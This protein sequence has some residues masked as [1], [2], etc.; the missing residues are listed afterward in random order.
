MKVTPL[1]FAMCI[2]WGWHFPLLPRAFADVYDDNVV[3]VLDASGSMDERMSGTNIRKIDAAKQALKG[4]V[5]KIPSNTNVGF[6]VFSGRGYRD[7]WLYP[8]SQK[9]DEKLLFA[10]DIPESGG[11]TPLGEYIKKGADILLAQREKQHGYGTF[12]LLVVTDGEAN[13]QGRVERYTPEVIARGIRVDVIGVNMAKDH[14]LATRVHS[15]R[16]AND[17]ES[18]TKALTEVFAEVSNSS[19]DAASS[20]EAFEIVGALP[21]EVATAILSSLSSTGNHPIG[22][23]PRPK[24][25]TQSQTQGAPAVQEGSSGIGVPLLLLIFVMVAG[26]IVFAIV[27]VRT[28]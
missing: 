28:R 12:R 23:K 9:N 3:I 4:V 11:G 18:F 19:N 14:T 26:V 17:P 13:D 21:T 27:V 24:A 22:E 1:I 20:D 7:E 8:L 5:Q 10:I 16:R 25:D 2:F 15:Y 6:L